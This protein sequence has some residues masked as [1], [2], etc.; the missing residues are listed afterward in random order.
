MAISESSIESSNLDSDIPITAAFDI[1]AIYLT[2]SILRSKLFYIFTKI[3]ITFKNN[4]YGNFEQVI[5]V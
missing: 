5:P 2:S 1:L 3:P 4:F